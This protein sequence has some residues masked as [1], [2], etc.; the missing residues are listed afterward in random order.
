[1]SEQ[2]HGRGVCYAAYAVVCMH[3]FCAIL[4][5]SRSAAGNT[6]FAATLHTEIQRVYF[7]RACPATE[8]VSTN[9]ALYVLSC[10]SYNRD[11][12]AKVEQDALSNAKNK[13]VAGPRPEQKLLT[14]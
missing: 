10:C 6:A 11:S 4:Q 12:M 9:I 7:S 13:Q 5:S 2:I 8:V 1:M 3:T 14:C